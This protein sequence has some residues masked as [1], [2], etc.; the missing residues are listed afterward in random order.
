M[1]LGKNWT[2]IKSEDF[3]YQG[4]DGTAYVYAKLNS[5]SIAKNESYVDLEL[6]IWH[7]VWVKSYDTDFYLTGYGWLGYAYREY[8]AGTTTIMSS[9]ITVSHAANGTGSFKATG[10][11]EYKG[12]GVSAE[13]FESSSQTLPTIPRYA[14]M[15]QSVDSKTETSISVKWTASAT[16]DKLWY[17]INNGSSWTEVTTSGTSGTYTI[18]GLTANT[19]YQLKTRGRRKDSQLTSDTSATAVT[20]YAYPY[21]SSGN[22]FAIGDKA[23]ITIYNPLKRTV[24]VELLDVTGA[25]VGTLQTAGTS[26]SGYD[27]TAAQTALYNSIPNDTS[28]AYSVA[29]TVDGQTAT[30]NVRQIG[31]YSVKEGTSEPIISNADYEDPLDAVVAITGDNKLIVRNKS[32]CD[33]S[34]TLTAQNGASIVSAAVQL[35]TLTR[36]MTIKNGVATVRFTRVYDASDVDAII[37]AVD[38]RGLTSTQ[39]LR[40]RV[41]NWTLPSAIISA[42][43]ENNFYSNTE[44]NVDA[45]WSIIGTNAIT[46]TYEATKDGDS[47]PTYTGSAQDNVPFVLDLNNDYAWLVKIVLTDSFDG[48]TTYNLQVSR[49]M[50]IVFYD[51]LISSTGFNCFPRKDHS[52]FVNDQLVNKSAVTTHGDIS[53]NVSTSFF[54]ISGSSRSGLLTNIGDDITFHSSIDVSEHVKAIV[55][56]GRIVFTGI[57]QP[58]QIT[59]TIGYLG[60]LNTYIVIT[61]TLTNS[62]QGI[63]IPMTVLDTSDH[64]SWYIEFKG[65]DTNVV[66]DAEKSLISIHSL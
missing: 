39:T 30:R 49:G 61:E 50:P 12:I 4:W 51:R 18:T 55:I 64:K 42:Q 53:R 34:A 38:S 23:T 20:T 1:A 41:A 47:S 7:S 59:I 57:T 26:V 58:T 46:I 31:T 36:D 48:T 27:G 13:T 32:F 21:A 37:T 40:I 62:E 33:I 54:I 44:I 19:T 14:T 60:R 66:Y 11:Y 56:A 15:G 6:R 63:T 52:V 28:A 25:T 35:S 22:N 5:Q 8:D 29:C 17:S 9:Q 10:G 3:T 16:I 45:S 2:Q 24:N 65:D 43:R